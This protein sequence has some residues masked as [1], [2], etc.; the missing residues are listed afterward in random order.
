M[1]NNIIEEQYFQL[2]KVYRIH[3]LYMN[4]VFG[5]QLNIILGIYGN[6]F[7]IFFIVSKQ[8]FFF[9]FKLII[10]TNTNYI[11]NINNKTQKNPSYK[12]SEKNYIKIHLLSEKKEIQFWSHLFLRNYAKIIN[13]CLFRFNICVIYKSCF[14]SV[15]QKNFV[16]YYMTTT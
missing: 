12:N 14:D 3:Y 11:I 13:L 16:V 2:H 5:V 4:H 6:W 15:T 9:L 10:I 1:Y 8:F 7:N